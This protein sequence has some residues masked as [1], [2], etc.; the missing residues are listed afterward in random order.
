MGRIVLPS[1][2]A[3]IQEANDRKEKCYMEIGKYFKNV[4]IGVEVNRAGMPF[5]KAQVPLFLLFFDD[6]NIKSFS[7]VKKFGN[8]SIKSFL[9][10]TAEAKD[11]DTLRLREILTNP[12]LKS[13]YLNQMI[14]KIGDACEKY[15]INNFEKMLCVYTKENRIVGG[16]RVLIFLSRVENEPIHH[17][18]TITIDLSKRYALIKA[19]RQ[20]GALTTE[21]HFRQMA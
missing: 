7:N 21:R 17:G 3:A 12:E 11:K 19:L 9:E 15:G 6:S 16:A 2:I 8:G 10:F 14:E 5:F 18:S 13:K 20:N 4:S 1:S